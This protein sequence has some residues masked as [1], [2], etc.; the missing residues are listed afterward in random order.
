MMINRLALLLA[1]CI[2]PFCLS[3]TDF[4][5][6]I[7]TMGEDALPLV[8]LECDFNS[9]SY[10]YFMQGKVT[11]AQMAGDEVTLVSYN[12]QLRHRGKTALFLPKKSFAMKLVDDEGEK[13]DANLLGLR[14]DNSWIFDA[15]GIDRFRM[16]NR[17][18]FNIWN[19]FS[20]TMW[21]T[22]FN[23]RNGTVG[24]M[25]EVFLNG[26]YEGIYCLSDKINRQLLNL[27]KAKVD[28]DGN[29]TVKG[30]LY[31]GDNRKV[32]NAL[33]N[34]A[35]ESTDSTL[36]N[37]FELQYPDEYP[38]L[39]TWQ[40]LMN[41]IDFNSK[42]ELDYFKEH[43]N[44][45]YYIDNLID[46]WCFKVAFCID[47][48]PYKNTFLSVPDINFDHRFMITPWDLDA[49]FGRD[50]QGVNHESTSTTKML[51]AYA[52]YN[53]LIANN[54]DGF[55][56]RVAQR[57]T[58]LV[59]T[60]FSP[61]NVESHIEPIYQ[62]FINSGAWT[63]EY[64]RW[65]GSRVSILSSPVSEKNFIMNWYRENLDFITHELEAWSEEEPGDVINAATI[66]LIYN[67]ILD[68][69]STYNEKIDLNHDN[70]INSAD[71]TTAYSILLENI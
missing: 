18:L 4:D 50:S 6:S 62:Q 33:T 17:V 65:K 37:S 57:W 7:A 26:E 48:M 71:I 8:N 28:S 63:R 58:Q 15:M 49:S 25:V 43:Y 66:T 56:Q 10:L 30:I 61:E 46:F 69:N 68:D 11:I 19:E 38:S 24:T 12:C 36:W 40:P 51:N 42:T 31:K 47:D 54:I 27:R 9:M 23:N 35:D 13:L 44:E 64:E 2:I 21:N 52:P 41:L 22:N 60:V 55:K 1:A 14:N 39:A 67:H 45:W 5:R 3:A 34:Y 70:I 32:S 29:V 53:R 16:R 59:E 20:H